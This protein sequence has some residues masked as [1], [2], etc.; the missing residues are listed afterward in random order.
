MGHSRSGV[1]QSDSQRLIDLSKV[2][3][4]TTVSQVRVTI[5]SEFQKDYTSK[6]LDEIEMEF[7]VLAEPTY[8]VKTR[9]AGSLWI[10]AGFSAIRLELEDNTILGGDDDP[11][12]AIVDWLS[13]LVGK[14]LL[15]IDVQ[16]PAGDTSFYFEGNLALKCFPLMSKD[17]DAWRI[18][19]P[20][21]DVLK[22]GPG[23]RVSHRTGLR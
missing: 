11:P 14:K 22:L 19:T 9:H 18:D 3:W 21:G 7:R 12:D 5:T 1:N 20:A 16:T 17:G 2:I 13:E 6:S 8:R 10:D 23:T 4:E 15:Q